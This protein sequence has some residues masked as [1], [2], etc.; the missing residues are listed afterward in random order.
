[1][2]SIAGWICSR[3]KRPRTGSFDGYCTE[4]GRDSRPGEKMPHI[5]ADCR[6]G[7]K[8]VMVR[9]KTLPGRNLAP[10]NTAND[11]LLIWGGRWERWRF[12]KSCWQKAG[13]NSE[14]SGRAVGIVTT[15]SRKYRVTRHRSPKRNVRFNSDR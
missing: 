13:Q 9:I 12:N 10:E 11:P 15:S 14:S 3:G 5:T 1:M 7:R 6:R 2:S 4:Y 8:N